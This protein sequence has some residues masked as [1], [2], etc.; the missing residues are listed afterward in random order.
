MTIR[1]L[2][3]ML[4]GTCLLVWGCDTK[5]KNVDSCGDDF[6][7]PGEECDGDAM[8]AATCADLGYYG[9]EGVLTC[10]SD[11]TF[12]L[13]VCTGGRCG[14]G[15]IQTVHGEQCDGVNLADTSCSELGLGG[16]VLGCKDVCR[17]DVSLCELTAECG[18][19][20][21]AS[22]F[23]PCDGTD[24]D[25]ETCTSLGFYGGV[26]GCNSECTAFD[27][28][29]CTNCGNDS[30]DDEEVCD[31]LDLNGQTC[32]SQGFVSGTLVCNAGCSEFFT[33]GCTMCGNGAIDGGE[34]CDGAD[35]N[36]QSCVSQGWYGGTLSCS[37]D[38]QAFDDTSCVLAGRCGDGVIQ[39]NYG[40]TC[41]GSN[42]NGH[43]C[44]TQGF[45]SGSL[46]CNPACTGFVTSTC[47][48][49]GNGM[50]DES[51]TCDGSNLNGQTCVTRGF[52][53]GLLT[54][55]SGCTGFVTSTC[56]MNYQSQNIGTMVYVAAGTFQRDTMG[57]NLS[58]VSAFRISQYE[59]TRAQWMAVTGWLDPSDP[60]VSGG[61]S[62]PVQSVSWYR[63]VAFCN[64]LSLLEG[65]D[66]SLLSHR[67]RF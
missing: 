34:T 52:A 12:N 3:S 20:V 37:T 59:I 23:E 44:V 29:G 8:T 28:S 60:S 26:L 58:I 55:N 40:E 51:E 15:A 6:L 21:A 50:I 39:G 36:G 2:I 47:T 30:V 65:V 38:C 63:V 53:S 17:W 42:L 10:R 61:M 62:D 27:T 18:D 54:C 46:A 5:T 1:T 31:G 45:V 66:A 33:G 49:C 14:D 56:T 11:C 13:A 32:F 16:G 9:Q 4:L 24:L 48:M 67:C 43:T 57:P 19:L 22:P 25:D 41:D 35:M 7:D 64:K